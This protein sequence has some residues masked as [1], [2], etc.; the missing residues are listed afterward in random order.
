MPLRP[1]TGSCEGHHRWTSKDSYTD[2]DVSFS[3]TESDEEGLLLQVI[4]DT[5]EG[6][7]W[8]RECITGLLLYRV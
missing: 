4:R 8:R 2:S 6:A 7:S 5:I 3:K 1:D